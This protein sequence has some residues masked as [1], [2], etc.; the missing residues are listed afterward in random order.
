G[1]EYVHSWN[2]KY[3]RPSGLATPDFHEPMRGDLLWIYEGLTE[4]WG[5]VLTARAQLWTPEQARESL[6]ETLGTY[7]DARPG[8]AWRGIDDT[9]RDPVVAARRPLPYRSWQMSEEY[10]GGGMLVWLATDLKLR[11][12]SRD[13]RS[14]DDL[15]R[16]SV[17]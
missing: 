13:R 12:L 15:D 9:T 4:Y 14:L 16:K 2:G 17:V 8:F 6:A 10:Y 3:R 11:E 7:A 1:H 5:Q